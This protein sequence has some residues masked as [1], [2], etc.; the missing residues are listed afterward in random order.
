M[1]VLAIGDIHGSFEALLALAGAVRLTDDDLLIT[2]GD[3]V[4]RGPDSAGVLDWLIERGKRGKLVPLLGNHER[5]MLDAGSDYVA[6]EYWLSFG[7]EATLASYLRRGGAGDLD[8]VPE[9]HWQFINRDCRKWY[10]TDTHFFVHANALADVPL[11]EQRDHVLLWERFDDPA[12]HQSGKVMVCGHTPQSSGVPLNLGHAVCIDTWAYG[13]GWLTCLD[14]ASGNYWQAN[15]RRQTRQGKL[16][17]PWP[18]P[19]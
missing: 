5:M 9:A 16:S 12:P 6:R 18:R 7:G 4:D 11:D 14:V 8:E 10:E 3:Y 19:A 13:A 2:L 1:R 15:Q 17:Q